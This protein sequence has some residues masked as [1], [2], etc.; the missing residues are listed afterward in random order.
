MIA[1]FFQ[2]DEGTRKFIKWQFRQKKEKR[3]VQTSKD[4]FFFD[5]EEAGAMRSKR[6]S[7]SIIS[8][9]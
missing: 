9:L 1:R 8:E 4:T 2:R 3:K 5:W 6:R 7:N